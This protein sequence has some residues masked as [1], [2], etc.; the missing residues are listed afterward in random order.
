M[1]TDCYVWCRDTAVPSMA[2]THEACTQQE[3][4]EIT[5][6]I[7]NVEGSRPRDTRQSYIRQGTRATDRGTWHRQI[8]A[9]TVAR[10][11]P[12]N[13]HCKFTCVNPRGDIFNVM[14]SGWSMHL[15]CSRDSIRYTST[16]QKLRHMTIS[17]R[18]H[19]TTHSS[20]LADSSCTSTPCIQTST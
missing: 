1:D 11:L 4:K 2:E 6:D 16:I 3:S 14:R 15:W 8:N 19:T 13:A 7:P 20:S 9:H 17:S 10:S 18:A 12:K 5:T